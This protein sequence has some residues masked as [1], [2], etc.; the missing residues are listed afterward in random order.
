MVRGM[1]V[2]GYVVV[3]FY[4]WHDKYTAPDTGDV[5]REGPEVRQGQLVE[6]T[7]LSAVNYT[8]ANKSLLIGFRDG[9]GDAHYFNHH[10]SAGN[11]ESFLRGRI[12]L[13]PGER[14]IGTVL[15]PSASDVLYFS[16]HGLVYE[17]PEGE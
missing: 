17:T 8:T 2:K 1:A 7:H 15:S 11:Y 16:A 12:M 5:T 6:I 3:G 9:I 4:R 10:K 14:P 13:L